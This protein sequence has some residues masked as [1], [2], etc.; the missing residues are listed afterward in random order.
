[1]S[2]SVLAHLPLEKLDVII[3]ATPTRS[4]TKMR[5]SSLLDD[6]KKDVAQV[7]MQ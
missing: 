6:T 5:S 4:Q 7:M 2:D 1:M 3:A